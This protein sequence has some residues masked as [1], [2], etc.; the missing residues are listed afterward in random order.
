[1]NGLN[2]M[3]AQGVRP[4]QIESPINQ[5]AQFEQIRGAQQA[6]MLRQQQ[7]A[8]MQRQQQ[9]TTALNQLY[10]Q[11]FDPATGRID[12]KKLVGGMAQ[13]GFGSNIMPFLKQS[14][15]G[16][17]AAAKAAKASTES[18]LKRIE[19]K[20]TQLENVS[21]P[22]AYVQWALSSFDDPV[23]G[24]VLREIGS[25]PEQ[26]MAEI[27][28]AAQQPNALQT[29]IDRSR[30][31][32]VELEKLL[33]QRTGQEITMR[34]QDIQATTT[35]R[36]QDIQ[37]Q[38]TRR[39][40]DIT[41][42][43]ERDLTLQQNIASAKAFGTELAK[44][45]VAAEAA[46]P[47]AIAT[48]EQ[49]LALIDDMIGDARVSK[50]GKRWEVPKGG[51]APAPGFESYVGATA[52]PFARLVEGSPAASYERRQLQIEGKTFLEAFESLKGGGAITEIEGQKG[53]QAI[54]RMNK[55][56]SEVEYV[57]AARELQDI[58]RKGVERARAKAGG[59]AATPAAGGMNP[60]TMSDDELRRA[61]GL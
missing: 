33:Q 57:R 17:E 22:D 47:N 56:Q 42:R 37:A 34:G 19:L 10:Q 29:L 60:A 59:G 6:N 9:Q 58:V 38:T 40:Q 12:E 3:I 50:D 13:G 53:T 46:L 39:G 43:R 24:P 11:A 2:Q 28:Q 14:A 54:S 52:M 25:T 55:A 41:D 32:S 48:A 23:L 44:N 1:M 15:E 4:I 18:A 5:M 49:T 61:L 35:R 27:N 26:V 20:R 7:M 36:G 8:E 31:G 16:Q 30:V 51:R 21:T 45:K